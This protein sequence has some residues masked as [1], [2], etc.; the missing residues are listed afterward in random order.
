MAEWSKATDCKPV[1]PSVRIRLLAPIFAMREQIKS[2]IK[3]PYTIKE[4]FMISESVA[5]VLSGALLSGQ[6]LVFDDVR[7]SEMFQIE[8]TGSAV[9]S[10]TKWVDVSKQVGRTHSVWLVK[11]GADRWEMRGVM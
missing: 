11:T 7:V 10:F 5:L 6:G 2:A 4:N 8:A 9:G 3:V 1:Q